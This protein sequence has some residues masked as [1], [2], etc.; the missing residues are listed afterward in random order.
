LRSDDLSGHRLRPLNEEAPP[1]RVGRCRR[2]SR[3]RGLA[4]SAIEP[5]QAGNGAALRQTPQR[6][7]EHG[8]EERGLE[9]VAVRASIIKGSRR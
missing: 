3:R 7:R 5:G 1:R 9:T 4:C 2:P 6:L 8:A